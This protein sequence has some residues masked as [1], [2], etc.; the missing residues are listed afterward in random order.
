MF[1]D[2]SVIKAGLMLVIGTPVL[3]WIASL[4]FGF[5]A[6]EIDAV[7]AKGLANVFR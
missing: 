6:M 2:G 5:I 7:F 3:V 1:F 4:L